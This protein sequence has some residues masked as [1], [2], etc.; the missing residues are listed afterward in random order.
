M[1]H[2]GQ[3]PTI[4]V[5]EESMAFTPPDLI[6]AGTPKCRQHTSEG[7]LGKPRHG[8]DDLDRDEG[9]LRGSTTLVAQ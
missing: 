1:K 5:H 3:T 8:D 4:G 2:E 6:E 9:L 7:K